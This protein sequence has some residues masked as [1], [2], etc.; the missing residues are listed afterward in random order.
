M[1]KNTNKIQKF[2]GIILTTIFAI[3]FFA[4]FSQISFAITPYEQEKITELENEIKGM[5]EEYNKNPT[6][7]TKQVISDREGL[8]KALK[9]IAAKT[10]AT[11]DPTYELKDLKF[12]VGSQ[13]KLPGDDQPKTY[14]SDK[15]YT[16]IVS[17]V[18]KVINY[19][20]AIIG[21]IAM[22]IFIIAGFMFMIAQGDQTKI[23]KAK[24]IFKYAIFGLIITFLSYIIVIFTQ[25]LFITQS[26]ETETNTEE[27]TT[28]K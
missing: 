26:L 27:T 13:L 18:L 23:D 14:F 28:T 3:T 8:L 17:L 4:T 6:E 11:K 5:K 12:N 9:D 15:T 25:S 10:P 2:L 7:E 21:T 20:T 22:I 16:P 24:E 1:T 19:A